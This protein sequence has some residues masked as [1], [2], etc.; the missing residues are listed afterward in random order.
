MI[1]LEAGELW[2]IYLLIN[3]GNYI[4]SQIQIL[5]SKIHSPGLGCSFMNVELI[6]E[7]KKGFETTW[8]FKCKMCN[9][10]T[11]IESEKKDLDYVPINKAIINGTYA[12]GIRF[13]QLAEFTACL[14]IPCMA[15]STY[16][17]YSDVLSEDIEASAWNVMKQA[18][19]EEKR[20]ALEANDVDGLPMCP[21]IA[22]GQWCKKNYKTKYDAFSGA[23]SIYYILTF[24]LSTYRV[25]LVFVNFMIRQK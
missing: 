6:N 2:I 1:H 20:L 10:L 5:N 18:G 3:C 19:M 14:D 9:L 8:V 25:I 17:K 12:I 15:P 23:V 7:I 22:V 13:T 11:T 16:I 21:V 4:F 24:T